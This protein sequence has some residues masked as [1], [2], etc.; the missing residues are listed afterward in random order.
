MNHTNNLQIEKAKRFAALHERSG[1][2]LIPNPWDGGSARM[3]EHLGFEALATSSG[4]CAAT[5]GR[6]DGKITRDEALAHVRQIV[7]TTN[8]PVAA[9][10][11]N[12]FADTPEAVAETIRLG[13]KAGL[14]GGSIEDY[15]G[16]ASKG[17]YDLG[18]ATER[19][20][21]A[22]E[23][24][25]ALSFKFKLAARAENFI[26]GNPSLDDTIK[27]LVAYEKAG[28]D[29]LFAPGL[30]DLATVR[31]VCSAVR[32][33]VNFMV[34]IRGKSFMVAELVAAGVK[35]ISFASSFY[36]AALAGFLTA[37]REV[38]ESGTFQ[39]LDTALTTPQMNE[40]LQG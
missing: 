36:R 11:E 21:A 25:Q 2:F 14:V 8:L 15:T 22:A 12:G 39:Y 13:A 16:D 19:I 29:V 1:F 18:H 17:Q 37:A 26:R 30:P 3:L 28:A 5:L 34:G 7:R 32:K 33:P 23:A 24:A 9:D 31:E 27:R 10:L 38:K 40:F 4:A 6:R 20:A 35:R